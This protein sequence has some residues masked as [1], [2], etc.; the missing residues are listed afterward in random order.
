MM[1]GLVAAG[2]DIILYQELFAHAILFQEI[3]KGVDSDIVTE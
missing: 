1:D 2:T 3:Q